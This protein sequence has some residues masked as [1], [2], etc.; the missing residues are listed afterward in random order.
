MSTGKDSV[1]GD[2][3]PTVNSAILRQ[4]IELSHIGAWISSTK[5]QKFGVDSKYFVPSLENSRHQSGSSTRIRQR[6]AHDNDFHCNIE[7]GNS[8]AWA[9][10]NGPRNP[11]LHSK[12]VVPYQEE[13]SMRM[14]SEHNP[15][16]SQWLA[17]TK[18]DPWTPFEAMG[19]KNEEKVF[20]AR[21]SK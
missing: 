19:F 4:D 3:N 9:F 5:P 14:K 20:S 7:Y 6:S 8:R 17:Q 13:N 16:V 11:M 1:H 2:L 10:G 15:V 12:R 18:D 21:T